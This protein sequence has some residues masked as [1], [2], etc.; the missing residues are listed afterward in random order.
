[1]TPNAQRNSVLLVCCLCYFFITSN[2]NSC[3]SH[4]C[5]LQKYSFILLTVFVSFP[6]HIVYSLLIKLL[7][8]SQ[9]YCAVEEGV[10]K[11]NYS[12]PLSYTSK[13][14]NLPHLQ[15]SALS[16]LNRQKYQERRLKSHQE[17]VASFIPKQRNAIKKPKNL[18]SFPPPPPPTKNKFEMPKMATQQ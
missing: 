3:Q 6:L 5:K 14:C 15:I 1:M 7:F 10:V 4:H 12:P 16:V 17:R 18:A 13:Y 8:M 2:H 9:I 11:S